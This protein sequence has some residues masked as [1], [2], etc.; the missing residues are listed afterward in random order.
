MKS[1]WA[2]AGFT[3]ILAC[4]VHA[5]EL[6]AADL[7]AGRSLFSATAVPACAIC[8]TLKDA[9]AEGTIGPSL[10]AQ[11]PDAAK[12]RTVLKTGLGVMPAYDMLTEAQ[13]EALSAY[14]AQVAGGN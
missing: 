1:F 14:V 7:D 9:G 11:K 6:S 12:V 13:I 3:S 2:I 5:G 4:Q 8:H 10:D